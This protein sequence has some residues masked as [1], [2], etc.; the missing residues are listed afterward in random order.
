[1]INMNKKNF[2]WSSS[3]VTIIL[4]VCLFFSSCLISKTAIAAETIEDL[5]I[6]VTDHVSKWI[7]VQYQEAV[8]PLV[9]DDLEEVN[10]IVEDLNE[11]LE[12]TVKNP[13]YLNDSEFITSFENK[14]TELK[15]IAANFNELANKT[16][17]FNTNLESSLENF[18]S[19]AKGKVKENSQKTEK[20]FNELATVINKIT[21]DSANLKLKSGTNT[22]PNLNQSANDLNQAIEAVNQAIESFNK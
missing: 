15:E 4:V 11:L 5:P 7:L 22:P 19:L 2:H 3:F 10:E 16:E 20:A 21:E 9:D 6:E 8:K 1:M 13:K 18:L 14:Q 12:E 17:K